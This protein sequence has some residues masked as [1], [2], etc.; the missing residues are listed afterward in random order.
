MVTSNKGEKSPVEV[1]YETNGN[2]EGNPHEK[3]DETNHAPSHLG[4]AKQGE[5]NA[6]SSPAVEKSPLQI[7]GLGKPTYNPITHAPNAFVRSPAAPGHYY[8]LI[9]GNSKPMGE[10]SNGNVT[11]SPTESANA[12]TSMEQILQRGRSA[13]ASHNR[14]FSSNLN[15]TQNNPLVRKDDPSLSAGLYVAS[16]R[17]NQRSN[18]HSREAH[19]PP[20]YSKKVFQTHCNVSAAGDPRA[21]LGSYSQAYGTISKTGLDNL[22]QRR[23]HNH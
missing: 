16:A 13:P 11:T 21:K 6:P 15:Q 7:P 2:H 5:I 8:H 18:S 23:P 1:N 19:P 20:R 10:T 12:A 17:L 14:S 4:V 9:A 3:I 22:L